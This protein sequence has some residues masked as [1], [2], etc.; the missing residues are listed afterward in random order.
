MSN[1]DSTIR[2]ENSWN[3]KKNYSDIRSINTWDMVWCG[4]VTLG[5]ANVWGQIWATG[6]TCESGIRIKNDSSGAACKVVYRDVNTLSGRNQDQGSGLTFGITGAH[7]VPPDANPTVSH[8]SGYT[9]NQGEE[10]FIEG[11]QLGYVW[12]VSPIA[13][14]TMSFWAN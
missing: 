1:Y 5:T 4:G 14:T 7:L 3:Y 9:L 11:R 6:G 10:I 8:I 2:G 13:G 12:V